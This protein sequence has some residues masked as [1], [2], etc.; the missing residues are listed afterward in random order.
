MTPIN[1]D[2]I[3]TFSD[4]FS[5][6]K[7]KPI[8]LYG[9]SERTQI[10]LENCSDFNF[11]GLMD[12][13]NNGTCYGLPILNEEEVT[14]KAYCIII[15]S[16]T[17]N[18]NIIYNRIQD[19]TLKNNILVYHLNGTLMKPKKQNTE[20][21]KLIC[22]IDEYKKSIE[23]N[24]IIL[25]ELFDTLIMRNTL[26]R[27]DIFEIMQQKLE[28]SDKV[29][30]FL[31]FANRRNKIERDLTDNEHSY[32]LKDIY[33][34]YCE[35]VDLDSQWVSKLIDLEISTELKNVI[36]RTD[37]VSLLEYAKTLGKEII[38]SAPSYL[39][40]EQINMILTA[41]NIAPDSFDHIYNQLPLSFDR[42][43]DNNNKKI[44]YLGNK[45]SISEQNL[46]YNKL[47][48]LP[49]YS[50]SE[51]ATALFDAKWS[52]YNN[53]FYC[54]YVMG[55]FISQ[56]LNSPFKLNKS[57]TIDINSF[58][59]IGYIFF[60]PIVKCF[61]DN[62]YKQ[63]KEKGQK[64]IFQARDC[65][66]LKILADKYYTQYN[67]ENVYFLTS[68]RAVAI[69]GI[70]NNDDIK[71]VYNVFYSAY[72]DSFN[73][74]CSVIFNISADTNDIYYNIPVTDIDKAILLSHIINNYSEQIISKSVSQYKYL[75]E[76]KK[77]LNISDTQPL[78]IIN[79]VGSGTTQAFFEKIKFNTQSEYYYFAFTIQGVEFDL[80]SP[81]NY[82]YGR[83][84]IY[85]GHDNSMI[86]RMTFGECI[87][88][89]PKS[90]FMGF[91]ENGEYDFCDNGL[92]SQYERIKDSHT[93]IEKYI[94]QHNDF[95]AYSSKNLPMLI[96]I[97]Y[98]Y[99]FDD[100]ICTISNDLKENFLL[101]DIVKSDKPTEI[102]SK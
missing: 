55:V 54:R 18:V 63:A 48:F 31:A 97:M 40:S 47:Q 75:S 57:G 5:H 45:K 93:G 56:L 73:K 10:I 96:N 71:Q 78:A 77:S 85:T 1:L 46:L 25:F 44:L 89:S 13:Q 88:T 67:V 94:K 17:F 102:W 50:S 60:G 65:W 66:I 68:R 9:C 24:D 61:M 86:K 14:Q 19:W 2:I 16:T 36:P 79:F 12:K 91:K 99:L 21:L 62:L 69:A 49:V 95:T 82:I 37:V 92:N 80:K 41:C 6:L 51:I 15:I 4:N 84:S 98:N 34:K 101:S 30:Y 76:Y 3:K 29:R 90:Q 7:N 8:V 43:E 81:I 38:L 59:E 83:E 20:S 52:R 35:D 39:S 33:N 11:I 58:E 87:F 28:N 22:S 23:S 70:K 42:M 27:S 32:I 26:Y 53:D 64:I 74:F 100:S 72:R